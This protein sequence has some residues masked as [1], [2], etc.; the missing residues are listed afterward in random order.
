MSNYSL[1][2]LLMDI[3]SIRQARLKSLMA[4]L[5][6]GFGKEKICS[7]ENGL[8]TLSVVP[9]YI[10]QDDIFKLIILM[11]STIDQL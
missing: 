10:T 6:K 5:G 4:C 1:F 11:A 2:P 8:A 3:K 9:R 7:Q